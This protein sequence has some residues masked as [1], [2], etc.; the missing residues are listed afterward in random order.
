M[1]GYSVVRVYLHPEAK[2]E[3]AVAQI[4]AGSNSVIRVLPPGITL[5]APVEFVVSMD[6]ES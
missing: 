1:Q 3:L 6:Q 5:D 4:S 2:V